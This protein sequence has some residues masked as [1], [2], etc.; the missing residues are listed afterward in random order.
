MI[1][2]KD[3]DNESNYLTEFVKIKCVIS[4]KALGRVN[5]TY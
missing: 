5:L 4:S 1:V 2:V 3:T